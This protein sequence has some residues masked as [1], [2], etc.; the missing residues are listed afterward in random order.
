M[1]TT[2]FLTIPLVLAG[3]T[4]ASPPPQSAPP[5]GQPYPVYQPPGYMAGPAPPYQAGPPPTQPGPTY[6]VPRPYAPAPIAAPQAAPR[7]QPQ[8]SPSAA[9]R[10]PITRFTADACLETRSCS[11][12]DETRIA[13]NPAHARSPSQSSP[14]LRCGHRQARPASVGPG[15][16]RRGQQADRTA[17]PEALLETIPVPH[18]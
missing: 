17:L 6:S 12:N 8:P 4:R 13:R 2:A 11:A 5:L 7:M 1:R 9:A 14:R 16:E 3:C 18:R 10:T 15:G